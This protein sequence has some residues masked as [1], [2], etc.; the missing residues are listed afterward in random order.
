VRVQIRD[1]L[2][3]MLHMKPFLPIQAVRDVLIRHRRIVFLLILLWFGSIGLG[4]LVPDDLKQE[5]LKGFAEKVAGVE[6]MG[7]LGIIGYIVWNN[8]KV[9]F[10]TV[11]LGVFLIIPV[12]ILFI[13]GLIIGVIADQ[14]QAIAGVSLGALLLS[15]LPHGIL[16]I[17]AILLSGILGTMLGVKLYFSKQFAPEHTRKAFIKE[18]FVVYMAVVVPLLLVAAVIEA[19]VSTFLAGKLI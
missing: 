12:I 5:L 10:L 11:V 4:F 19:T 2:M 17:P 7:T 13:N 15:L 18:I 8:L 9:S 6:D 1:I 3:D 14:V 16:E